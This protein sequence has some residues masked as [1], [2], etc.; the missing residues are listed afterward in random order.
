MLRYQF[1]HIRHVVHRIVCPFMKIVNQRFLP[2][3]QRPTGLSNESD[4]RDKHLL[5][6]L[7]MNRQSHLPDSRD[8]KAQVIKAFIL[9]SHDESSAKVLA[10]NEIFVILLES[11]L[12]FSPAPNLTR[13][14]T[15]KSSSLLLVSI[16]EKRL[17]LIGRRAS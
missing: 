11:C 9:F 14:Q 16:P 2:N 12:L 4:K 7:M 8:S 15:R 1:V 10:L 13:E 6:Q 17:S 5:F 3:H